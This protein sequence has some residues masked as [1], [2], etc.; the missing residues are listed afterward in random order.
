MNSE[1]KLNSK[2]L[3]SLSSKMKNTMHL[4]NINY[5]IPEFQTQTIASNKN[6]T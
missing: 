4:L 3:K 6:Q 5:A 2:N 1:K